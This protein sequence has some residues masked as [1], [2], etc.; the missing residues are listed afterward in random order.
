MTRIV[1]SSLL[2]AGILLIRAIFRK[3]ISPLI[4]YP[5]WLLAALR[6]LMPGVLFYSPISVMNTAVW[7][8]GSRM[9]EE[10]ADR[11]DLEYKMQ[12]YQAYY[13]HLTEESQKAA[14][15][16]NNWTQGEDMDLTVQDSKGIEA[17]VEENGK[18]Q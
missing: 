4:L 1:T 18:D 7:S 8:T 17:G 9:V 5:I 16:E 12:Q 15:A 11:Q 3:K 6:L 13:D 14:G 2:I 10:E